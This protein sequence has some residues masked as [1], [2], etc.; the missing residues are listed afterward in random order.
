[1][2]RQPE[3]SEGDDDRQDEF[4]AADASAKACLADSAQDAHITSYD[5]AVWQQEGQ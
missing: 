1:M 3:Q 2:V 4:L 5:H